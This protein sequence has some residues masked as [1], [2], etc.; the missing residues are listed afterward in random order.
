MT[1][2]IAASQWADV[3]VMINLGAEPT[4]AHLS[5]AHAMLNEVATTGNTETAEPIIA[6][7]MPAL[8]AVIDWRN[9]AKVAFKRH[10]LINPW[11]SM[12]YQKLRGR[13]I[14]DVLSLIQAN[15]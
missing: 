1:T 9:L 5:T 3:D 4:N 14:R 15:N 6:S 12:N 7:N 8:P 11:Y 2:S 13:M 10:G